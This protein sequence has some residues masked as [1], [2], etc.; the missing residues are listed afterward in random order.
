MPCL[1]RDICAHVSLKIPVLYL[2]ISMTSLGKYSGVVFP[3]TS[4]LI[5]FKKLTNLSRLV[6]FTLLF[7]LQLGKEKRWTLVWKWMQQIKME[8]D[9]GLPILFF[10]ADM[11]S[12]HP[13]KYAKILNKGTP[14]FRN[15]QSAS[16]LIAM[17]F[18]F[19][20]SFLFH[21]IAILK[22]PSHV[23]NLSGRIN[24]I[25][26]RGITDVTDYGHIFSFLFQTR[27][28]KNLFSE[29]NSCFC[30]VNYG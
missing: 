19:F 12:T 17:I 15:L 14:Y 29:E 28:F 16:L 23:W 1:F 6:L 9:L 11:F 3:L 5:E 21:R 27:E 24:C 10:Y 7:N 26:E 13:N 30:K 8:F 2:W 20:F 18:F 25:T 4:P 22:V